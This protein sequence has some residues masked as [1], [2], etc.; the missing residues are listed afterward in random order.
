MTEVDP[1]GFEEL[2][3]IF[4]FLSGGEEKPLALSSM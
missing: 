4:G 3:V 1:P 2:A